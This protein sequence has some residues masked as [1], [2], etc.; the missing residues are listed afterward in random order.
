MSIAEYIAR[1]ASQKQAAIDRFRVLGSIEREIFE[2][3]Y[4]WLL[5]NLDIKRG[6]IETDESLS[7]AMD[8]FLYAVVDIIQNNKK[9]Q[10]K[11]GSF[12]SDLEKIQANNQKFHATTNNFNIQTAGVT[13]VQQ[14]VV[15]E[16]I[17]QFLGNG[18]NQ[19]FAP[20]LRDA[21]FRNI[22]AGASLTEVRQTLEMHIISGQDESGKL[23]Q[24]LN[25][26]A[27]Q[28]VDAYTG[29]INQKLKDEFTFTGYIIS[30]S[31]IKTSSKQCIYAIE[32]SEEGYLSFKEWEKVLQ[33]ARENPKARL[34]EGTTIDNLPL[35]KLH[36]GCRH[37]FTPVIMEAKDKP[38]EEQPAPE[39][40]PKK[41]RAPKTP[42]AG[43]AGDLVTLEPY[44]TRIRQQDFESA[45]VSKN[46]KF[47][48]FKDGE[49]SRVVFTD[50][51]VA[52]MEGATGTHNHPGSRSFSR[53]DIA[54]FFHAKLERLRAVGRLAD[55]DIQRTS[56][57]KATPEQAIKVYQAAHKKIEKEFMD[58]IY[59]DKLTVEEANFT[60]HHRV[61]EI[62][63]KKLHLRYER[64][65]RK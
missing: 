3:S 11:V 38:Q 58:L 35:N 2:Q 37:D 6:K 45:A 47:L 14:M 1:L 10:G 43:T 24:Y 5:D 13:D 53:E 31:L 16:I 50:E 17:N 9:F 4:D 22:L 41:P 52:L 62:V 27:I 49:K 36:W 18:L 57:T 15:N 59:Y 30:G 8:S 56:K 42:K 20:P 44:E 33:M 65:E 46:G 40:P 61:L 54:L 39:P 60:H 26:T 51:E 7:R 32:T 55:H 28:A 48:Y 23:Q 21:I 63:A 19:H 12:L 64:I 34:I 29:A 25:N